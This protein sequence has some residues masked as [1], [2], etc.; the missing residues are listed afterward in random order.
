MAAPN[1]T[2]CQYSAVLLHDTKQTARANQALDRFQVAVESSIPSERS[3][4]LADMMV[5]CFYTLTRPQRLVELQALGCAEQ[6]ASEHSRGIDNHRATFASRSRAHGN[7]VFA[8]GRRRDGI[9]TR[10]EGSSLVFRDE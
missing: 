5:S 4:V 3:D 9:D 7:V 6:L 1:Q 8:I 2:S 10:R